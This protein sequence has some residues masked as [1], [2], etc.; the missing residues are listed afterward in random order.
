MPSPSYTLHA[1]PGAFRAF[2]IL[3]AAEYNGVTVDVADYNAAAVTAMSPSGKAPVLVCGDDG[4][5]L[6]GS[7]SVARYIAGIRQDTN[8]M[9]STLVDAA[10]VDQWVDFASQTLDLPC[11]IWFYPVA[12]YMAFHKETYEKAKKD[13]ASALDLLNKSLAA[14]KTYLVGD[15]ITLADICIA[16]TLLYP[17]KLV[18]DEEFLKPYP[19]VV[20]WFTTCVT[21]PEFAVIVGAVTM[22]KKELKAAGD[23]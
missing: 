7:T 1:P 12:G 3:I 20:R 16:S 4:T 10:Q 11:T 22:C 9:G 15:S 23:S 17:F 5:K 21:Q 8:L 6:F 19:N 2:P 13:L 14:E 18:C